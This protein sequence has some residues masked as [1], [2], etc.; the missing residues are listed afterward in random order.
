MAKRR[1]KKT[2]AKTS[3]RRKTTR[4]KAT[5]KKT[6]RRKAT[7]RKS[8]RKKATRRKSTRKK[9]A[10]RK[11]TRKKATRKKAK[12][13][14]GKR[15]SGLATK[16][17]SASPALQKIVGSK[18]L[19]RPQ[20]VKKMWDYIKRHKCQDANNRRKICPDANLAA[21]IGRKPVDMLKLAGCISKHVK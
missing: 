16:T 13:K 18:N 9:V 20:I 12:R 11:T 5:R 3:T 19:T 4:R 14:S 7:R 15:R 21:V 1:K 8:T 10:G 17:C 2:R 6:T